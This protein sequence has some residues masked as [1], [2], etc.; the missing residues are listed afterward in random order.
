MDDILITGNNTTF[1]KNFVSKLN[2]LFS[3]KDLGPVY[4]FLGL[5]I[6]RSNGVF[7]LSQSKYIVDLLTKFGLQDCAPVDT[8]MVTGK[9]FS[10]AD[11]IPLKDVTLYRRMVGSLQYLL[12]TRPEIAFAVN[13]LSQFLAAPTDVHF[14]AVKRV[15]RYLKGTHDL[16]LHLRPCKKLQLIT[17]T[18]ADWATN[19]DDRKSS[20]GFCVF[21]GDSLISWSSRKQRVVSRSS[22]ESEYRALVDGAAEVC[23]LASLLKEL[24]F[25]PSQPCVMKCDNLS[26]RALTSNPVQH[27]RSKH[28]EID[29][30]FV[31]DL[32]LSGFLEIQHVSSSSQIADCLRKALTYSQFAAFRDKLGLFITPSRLRGPVKT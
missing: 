29:V 12:T 16:G 25:S 15:F 13:K 14:Q 23:W 30:H 1:L 11:G 27:S 31:H 6:T 7:C 8:P 21:L 19:V 26:A 3:L 2:T 32:V 10:K 20:G 24:G 4:Y 18:D 9:Q 17:Y 5:E 22:T 28:I